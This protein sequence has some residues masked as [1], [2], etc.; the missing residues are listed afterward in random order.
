MNLNFKA[1]YKISLSAEKLQ[2]LLA[3][4]WQ[5][6]RLILFFLI[7]AGVCS[8]GLYIWRISLEASGWS[9]QRKQD[10][11]KTQEKNIT[12]KELDFTKVTTEAKTRKNYTSNNGGKFKDIFAP[13]K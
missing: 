13:Y 12:F 6:S 4:F 7:L 3:S 5:K 11:L 2:S 8:W 10:Y 9:E 1:N